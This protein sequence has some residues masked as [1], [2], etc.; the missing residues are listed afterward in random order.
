[1]GE[2]IGEK[3]LSVDFGELVGKTFEGYYRMD[4][5]AE[6]IDFHLRL[7]E[8]LRKD[9]NSPNPFVASMN[10]GLKGYFASKGEFFRD[11]EEGYWVI[12][13]NKD[14]HSS[15]NC[16]RSFFEFYGDMEMTESGLLVVKNG[17]VKEMKAV[18]RRGSRM[19]FA[20]H[21]NGRFEMAEK[22][23]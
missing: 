19:I 4:C 7:L 8:F 3:V 21:D 10:Q 11:D 20:C 23:D 17:T 1:M 5:G 12:N 18:S 6:N 22:A 15:G 9:S 2:N 13:F 16:Y 14:L